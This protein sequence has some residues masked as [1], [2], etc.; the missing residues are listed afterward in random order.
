MSW[1]G[2]Y[3]GSAE[4]FTAHVRKIFGRSLRGVQI[5]SSSGRL[6]GGDA[7]RTER[8]LLY[9]CGFAPHPNSSSS[10]QKIAFAKIEEFSK[11]FARIDV[12][13]FINELEELDAGRALPPW[14]ANV[15]E[16]IPMRI[17]R[18][19]RVAAGLLMP[20]LPMFVSV[21]RLAAGRE[22]ARR[23]SDPTYT[24]FYSDFSQGSAVLSRRQLTRFT[25]RQH[26][27][28]SKLYGRQA[29]N[30]GGLKKLFYRMEKVKTQ[31]WEHG[32]WTSAAEIETLSEEDAALIRYAH[33]STP[34]KCVPPTT[35]VALNPQMRTATT[36]VPGRMIFFGNMSRQENIDAV[37]WMARDILPQIHQRNPEAH[38]WIIGAHPSD[39]VLA[40]SG[41]SIHVTGFI[42]SPME[43]FAQAEVA[44][45][46]L[47][48]GSG[49]KIKVIETIAA[50]IPTITTPVGAEGIPPHSLL[51][52]VGSAV[53][54]AESVCGAFARE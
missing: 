32:V 31:A 7:L 42:E 20:H 25:V 54:F 30:A 38:L 16:K 52:V 8:R 39:E 1:I 46:P 48:L 29:D 21:R 49:V 18:G 34:V 17:T 22:I 51:T 19:M 40:L 50:G 27:V 37:I 5:H 10:G 28:V 24:D 15:G 43:L 33:P 53:E 4:G 41:P 26:D 14:P 2:T 23:L 45:V 47:R 13:Y 44:V 6:Q 36:I 9:I 35:T 3:L 11:S 12:L